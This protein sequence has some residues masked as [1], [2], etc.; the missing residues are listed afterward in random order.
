MNE[1][2]FDI[3]LIKQ[4]YHRSKS[5]GKEPIN[6]TKRFLDRMANA[7]DTTT[8]AC[9]RKCDFCCHLPVPVQAVEVLTIREHLLDTWP[10]AEIDKLIT[11]SK[12]ATQTV[13]EP[14]VFLKDHECSIYEAR[15]AVC[16]SYHS[17]NAKACETNSP[18]NDEAVVI[19]TETVNSGFR[20]AVEHAGLD[21]TEYLLPHALA[22]ALTDSQAK[23]RLNKGKKVFKTGEFRR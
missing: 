3:D 20:N 12:Q 6:S 23:D 19:A 22:Q 1:Q 15:P 13:G 10:R 5:V 11:R 2:A 9:R 18:V 7:V 4:E 8:L 17:T 21:T 14:C 16:R